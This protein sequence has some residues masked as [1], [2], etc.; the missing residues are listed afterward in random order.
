MIRIVIADDHPIVLS[1]LEQLFAQHED[2]QVVASCTNGD[3]ALAATRRHVPD[4][5]VLDLR[6]PG[7]DG[8]SVLREI[9]KESLATRVVIL[10]ANLTEREVIDA[11]RLGARGVVL[12]EMAPNLLVRCVRKVHAGGQW[13]EQDSVSRALDRMLKS[14]E[15]TA[16][17]PLTQRETEIFRLVAGGMRNKEV[18]NALSITEGTVKLHLHSI[19]DKL[20]IDGRMELMVHARKMGLV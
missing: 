6:M 15:A 12:K 19:Y 2:F 7:L 8:M 13:L 4:V 10:T 18:A 5:L 3:E 9:T 14:E 16:Q 1:G 11:I 20:K 17:S